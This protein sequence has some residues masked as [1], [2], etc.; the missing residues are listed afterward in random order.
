MP[1]IGSLFAVL[2]MNTTQ[3]NQASNT[4][5]ASL[6]KIEVNSRKL[7]FA[8]TNLGFQINDV[9]TGLASGQDPMRI[10]AQQA[11][12]IVQLFTQGGGFKAVMTGAGQAIRNF[13]TPM[14][15]AALGIG[16]VVAGIALLVNRAMDAQSRMRGFDVVMRGLGTQGQAS[17]AGLEAA[18]K[19]LR[20]VGL[21]ADEAKDKMVA[22]QRAGIAPGQSER[23]VRIG[24]NLIPAL[25]ENAPGALNSAIEGG[26][27]SLGKM[28]RQ[29]GLVSAAEIEAAREAEKYGQQVQYLNRWVTLLEQH[30]KGL[31]QQAMSP[32]GKAFEQ[33]RISVAGMLDAMANSRVI[34]TLVDILNSLAKTLEY[35]FRLEPPA[36]FSRWMGWTPGGGTPTPAGGGGGGGGGGTFAPG[37]AGMPVEQALA[38]I[39][40]HE[41]KNRELIG[42][43]ET[44]LSG[45]PLTATGFPNWPGKMGPKGRSTAAGLYQITRSTWDPIARSLGITD[46]SRHSQH[47]VGSELYRTRGF[48]PW[49]PHN[50][51]LAAALAAGGT[52]PGGGDVLAR[53]GAALEDFRAAKERELVDL[54]NE[55]ERQTRAENWIAGR[56]RAGRGGRGIAETQAIAEYRQRFGGAPESE[57]P[58]AGKR[59]I[60]ERTAQFLKLSQARGR[61]SLAEGGEADR[62]TTEQLQRQ[63]DLFG[64]STHEIEL[65]VNL[66]RVRQQAEQAGLDVTDEAVKAREEEVQRLSEVNKLLQ[67]QQKFMN[68]IREVAGVFE[69]AFSQAFDNIVEGTFNLRKAFGSLLKDLGKTLASS[70]FKRLLGGDSDGGGILGMIAGRLFN[71]GG[72]SG[73]AGIGIGADYGGG[74]ELGVAGGA[75]FATGGS[76]RVGGYGAMDSQLVAFRASPGE[77]VDVT[78]EGSYRGGGRGEVIRIDL[79]PSE[80]WVAGVADQRIVTRSGQIVEVAVRQ[81]QRTVQRNFGGMSAEAQARQL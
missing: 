50:E 30:S 9:A 55:T 27:E 78:P 1:Q 34:T 31:R 65:Q 79:N 70:A 73:G 22:A 64:K 8:L 7:Q 24:E 43:G 42:W 33:L 25:G 29:L 75:S 2:G 10:F 63:A 77:M 6:Q 66:L 36:W 48:Q 51:K 71:L 62:E 37:G 57:I 26:V 49:A 39:A 52:V 54:K 47:M 13:F 59:E 19:R 53:P 67:D 45:Y 17:A 20:D 15:A 69:N 80:G 44:D 72:S 61:R 68:Q 21:S 46:F 4:A 23:I 74:G 35:I 38:L 32:L 56:I 5:V 58:E 28:V 11:G 18:A 12:Q 40:H 14:R 81:S 41:S 76:F 3:F 16:T 60:D